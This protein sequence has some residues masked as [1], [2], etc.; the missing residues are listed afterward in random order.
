MKKQKIKKL[1][2]SIKKIIKCINDENL[3]EHE[4]FIIIKKIDYI[5]KKELPNYHSYEDIYYNDIKPTYL[6]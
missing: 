1:D 5:L 3:S 2:K 4:M 6:G